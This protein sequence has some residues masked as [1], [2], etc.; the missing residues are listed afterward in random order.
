MAC[1]VEMKGLGRAFLNII[2][3]FNMLSSVECHNNPSISTASMKLL[4]EV[5]ALA[6]PQLNSTYYM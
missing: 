6:S 5:Y 3:R 4:L 2:G 1:P